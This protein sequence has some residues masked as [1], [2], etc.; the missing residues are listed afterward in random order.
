MFRKESKIINPF[1]QEITL[2]I[3]VNPVTGQATMANDKPIQPSMLA[4]VLASLLPQIIQKVCETES[5][6]IGRQNGIVQPGP[7]P[8]NTETGE[9]I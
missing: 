1:S 9:A 5:M 2:T 6:I 4:L 8:E 3:K 7:L